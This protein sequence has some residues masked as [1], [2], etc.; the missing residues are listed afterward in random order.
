MAILL[1]P[2]LATAQ[3][4][5]ETPRLIGPE[6][7]TSFSLFWMRFGT[8][9]GDGDGM[10]AVWRSP[11]LPAGVTLRFG[12]AEGAGDHDA[13]LAGVD[14]RA[15]VSRHGAGQ[16]LDLCWTAGAGWGVGDYA[17]VTLPL[18]MTAGRSW[19]SGAL[20]V[21]PYLSAGV[22]MDLALGDDAPGDAFEV[23]PAMDVG[24]DLAV[25]RARRLVIRVGAALGDRHALALGLAVA[26]GADRA[27]AGS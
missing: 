7:P 16:P 14:I 2:T 10:M 8:L 5:W 27:G 17:L 22:A 11:G 9:P 20:W 13:F 1:V 25:D 6:S 26:P 19:S 18:G 24:I 15:P 23:S 12:A 21:A 3:V 4:P